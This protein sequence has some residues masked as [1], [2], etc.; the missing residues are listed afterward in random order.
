MKWQRNLKVAAHRRT[1]DFPVEGA[2]HSKVTGRRVK[3]ALHQM[4]LTKCAKGDRRQYAETKYCPRT[5]SA[6]KAMSW[7]TMTRTT[8]F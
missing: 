1:C 3:V 5:L 6:H 2:S 8:H 7:D 4:T